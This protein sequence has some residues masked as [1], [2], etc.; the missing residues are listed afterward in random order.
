MSAADEHGCS[1]AHWPMT[2]HIVFHQQFRDFH[3]PADDAILA[4]SCCRLISRASVSL[5]PSS[6]IPGPKAFP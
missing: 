5:T 4:G 6:V 2:A 3:K 1:V